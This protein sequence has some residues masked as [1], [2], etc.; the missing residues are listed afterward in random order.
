MKFEQN[1][2]KNKFPAGNV[3]CQ[4]FTLV[5]WVSTLMLNFL[6]MK[7][8][9]TNVSKMASLSKLSDL[10]TDGST[11]ERSD[12][13]RKLMETTSGVPQ[14]LVLSPLIWNFWIGDYP[15]KLKPECQSLL[16]ADDTGYGEPTRPPTKP[17]MTSN[18]RSGTSPTGLRLRELNLNQP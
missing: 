2:R 10:S 6:C 11:K 14:E 18:R 12:T 7:D 4:L 13:L 9:F 1:Q 3:T 8:L 16:Y 5:T 15:A 17:L